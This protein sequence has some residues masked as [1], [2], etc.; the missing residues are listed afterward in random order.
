MLLRAKMS[1]TAVGEEKGEIMVLIQY[2]SNFCSDR[3]I[4]TM[5]IS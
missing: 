1:D 2:F 3:Y 4:G 5:N